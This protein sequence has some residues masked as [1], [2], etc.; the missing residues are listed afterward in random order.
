MNAGQIPRLDP[1]SAL[2]VMIHELEI[3]G[4]IKTGPGNQNESEDY[5]NQS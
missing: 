4:S 5:H 2:S 1:L 3:A